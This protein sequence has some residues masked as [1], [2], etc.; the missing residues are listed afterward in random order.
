MINLVSVRVGIVGVGLLAN[1]AHI[2]SLSTIE[3]ADIVAIC[4]ISKEA[5]LKT[6]SKYHIPAMYTDLDEMLQKEK[7]DCVFCLTRP[8][9]HAQIIIK[10]LSMGIHVFSEKPLSTKLG[11]VKDIIRESEK[12]GKWIQV[13][14]NRR[15]TPVYKK[16]KDTFEKAEIR[17]CFAEKN[18]Q[19]SPVETSIFA[20]EKT[21]KSYLPLQEDTC[22]MIDVLN[23]FCGEPVSV[24]AEAFPPA[25]TDPER[26]QT[27]CA[28]IKYKDGALAN[29]IADYSG[30]VWMERFE[31]YGGNRTALV[32]APVRAT[33]FQEGRQ[34][35][36]EP[37]A[38][39]YYPWQRLFGYQQED[40]YFI[41]CVKTGKEPSPSGKDEL[42]VMKIINKIYKRVGVEPLDQHFSL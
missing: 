38:T 42:R 21:R 8:A 11:E 16:A 2:P 31:V 28:L 30:G 37:A 15:F 18:F 22:H 34:E 27:T 13:G 4:D 36:Y 6:A 41:E 29:V 3:D 17:V 9:S 20:Y 12:A 5:L 10:C 32:D 40:E 23:W 35:I 19:L 33:I 26:L 14:Y 24:Q 1:Q 25:A 39:F 7:L